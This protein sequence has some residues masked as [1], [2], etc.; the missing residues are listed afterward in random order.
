MSN[1]FKGRKLMVVGGTS[2]IGLQSAK[3]VL[4]EGGS[5]VIVGRRPEKTEEARKELASFGEVSA[6]TADL[7]T[8]TRSQRCSPRSTRIMRISIF[9]SMRPACSCRI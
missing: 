3:R 4:A 2:G 5:V 7:R 6:L 9:W 1:Q 8:T